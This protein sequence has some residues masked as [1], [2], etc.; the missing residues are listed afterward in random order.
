VK[1]LFLNDNL[2]IRGGADRVAWDSASAL[3]A[4]GED[5]S[6][7]AATGHPEKG[8]A[9]PAGI[10]VQSLGVPDFWELPRARALIA[11]VD[12][13]AL[14]P[15]LREV[16]NSFPPDQTLVHIHS[17]TRAWS[18]AVISWLSDWGYRFVIT[19]H[20]YFWFCPNGQFYVEGESGVCPRKPLGVSCLA[21]GCE[22]RGRLVKAWRSL[23]TRQMRSALSQARG[24][25]FP[26]PQAMELCRTYLGSVPASV[27]RHPISIE[28]EERI[29]A[30][31]N[32]DYIFVGRLT[33]EKGVGII[34][35]WAREQGRRVRF[36]GDGPEAERLRTFGD[37]C[38]VT[39][40]LSPAGVRQQMRKARAL[41]F[42]VLW[43]ETY[44]LVV[45]EALSQGLPVV[46]SGLAGASQRVDDG[47]SGWVLAD[48]QTPARFRRAM[49]KLDAAGVVAQMSREAYCRYWQNPM[50]YQ[51][52][53]RALVSWYRSVL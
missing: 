31:N 33:A 1:I 50:D 3:A 26:S 49:D 42:P 9:R 36:V 51:S 47:I 20:D 41:L 32:T 46:V 35:E 14:K 48:G 18:P 11:G 45:V 44:G 2:T 52:H 4:A 38:Q 29:R 8:E 22:R 53:A 40:W 25:L 6:F 5:V 34:A 28:R 16:L 10:S 39:G 13:A 37:S 27:I 17:V 30:E 43:P 12:R 21:C 7:L 23:R 15:L 19:C 24:I